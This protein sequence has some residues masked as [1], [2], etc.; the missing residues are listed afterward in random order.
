[1]RSFCFGA[2]FFCISFRYF[3]GHPKQ[4]AASA[5]VDRGS[6]RGG[7]ATWRWLFSAFLS[8]IAFNACRVHNTRKAEQ[9]IE[10][11]PCLSLS[12]A[13]SRGCFV[14]GQC[15]CQGKGKCS[16]CCCSPKQNSQIKKG[17]KFEKI[18]PKLPQ[19][20]CFLCVTYYRSNSLISCVRCLWL[21]N[22]LFKEKCEIKTNSLM[23]GSVVKTCNQSSLVR[24][25]FLIFIPSGKY[26]A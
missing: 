11:S 1:L 12:R 17:S 24:L 9:R 20:V 14:V 3:F 19:F 23:T 4:V 15:N 22:R 18:N 16:C 7:A 5:D 13:L 26:I 8:Q 25:M 6:G 10:R 2:L 21:I